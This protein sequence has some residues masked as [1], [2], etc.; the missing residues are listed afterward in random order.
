MFHGPRCYL[1]TAL[2]YLL[3]ERLEE[4]PVSLKNCGLFRWFHP[5]LPRT[6]EY[7][8]IN[9]QVSVLQQTRIYSLGFSYV[10]GGRRLPVKV[11]NKLKD[12]K[13]RTRIY[14]SIVRSHSLRFLLK[15]IY[16]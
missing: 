13:L 5:P 9:S 2:E 3:P 7:E 6:F 11:L 8:E 16:P 15:L 4:T 12:L 10:F 14:T 1:H